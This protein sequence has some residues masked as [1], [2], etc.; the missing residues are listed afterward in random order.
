LD[1]GAYC[2]LSPDFGNPLILGKF[3]GVNVAIRE[4]L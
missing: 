4:S 1:S 3:I 2:V